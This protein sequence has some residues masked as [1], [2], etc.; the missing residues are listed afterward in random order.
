MNPSHLFTFELISVDSLS[1]NW[2]EMIYIWFIV[3]G[4]KDRSKSGIKKRI[5]FVNLL[6]DINISVIATALIILTYLKLVKIEFL[7]IN[8]P[9]C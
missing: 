7:I 5:F 6:Y 8:F 3:V 1:T 4:V 2:D 9:V